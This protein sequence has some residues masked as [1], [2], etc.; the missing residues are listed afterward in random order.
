VVGAVLVASIVG[1]SAI[2]EAM[3]PEDG[4]ARVGRPLGLLVAMVVAFA[5]FS[6]VSRWLDRRDVRAATALAV[7]LLTGAVTGVAIAFAGRAVVT[8]VSPADAV[9]FTAERAMGGGVVIG[10]QAYTLWVLAFRYP[11]LVGAARERRSEA[12][13][14]RERA[15]L[16]QLRAH[17]QPHFLRNTI[18]SIA[19]LITEEPREARRMLATLSDLLTDTTEPSTP[20]HPLEAELRWLRRYGEILEARHRGRL[21]FVWDVAPDVLSTPVPKLLLQPL[22]ENAVLHGALSRDGGG[23]VRVRAQRADGLVAIA[24]EDN[25]PGL[26]ASPPRSGALGLHIVRRRLELEC[27]GARFT[28]QS[29]SR[30]TRSLVELT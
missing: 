23:E 13:R 3:A 10:L 4:R 12:S 15:E 26:D 16:M 9:R 18:S 6:A 14:L 19:A 11:A 21:S 8:I 25:G 2:R 30:G 20:M 5:T 17:L 27:P 22:V 7:G 1:L 29:T 28:L 24:I